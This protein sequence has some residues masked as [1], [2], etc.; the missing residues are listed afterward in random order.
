MVPSYR[1]GKKRLSI[2]DR[3]NRIEQ[4]GDGFIFQLMDGIR[5]DERA[6]AGF[7]WHALATQDKQNHKNMLEYL[8][9]FVI[10]IAQETSWKSIDSEHLSYMGLVKYRSAM[11]FQVD[12]VRNRQGIP[13]PPR[14]I[15]YNKLIEYMRIGWTDREK[16]KDKMYLTWRD[17]GL[18]RRDNKD[19]FIAT[20]T[21]RSLKTSFPG[22][23][24]AAQKAE[25]LRTITATVPSTRSY[26]HLIFSNPHRLLVIALRRGILANHDDLN[27]LLNGHNLQIRVAS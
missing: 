7:R 21:F 10:F 26:D 1:P 20:I 11:K 25:P 4:E 17:I 9:P 8:R 23:E 14:N 19:T 13:R 27:D 3:S 16:R 24:R 22:V 2:F 6:S 12:H 15:V 5:R 18:T